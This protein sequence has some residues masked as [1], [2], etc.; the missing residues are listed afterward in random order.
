M[1]MFENDEEAYLNWVFS[2][3]NGFV[4][5]TPK[6]GRGY[7]N[8]LHRATCIHITTAHKNYTTTIYKKACS[9]NR[10][11]LVNSYKDA[12]NGF[13]GCRHCKP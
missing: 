3:P 8:M 10:Q 1:D 4:I 5:N 7:P 12:A 11:E 9:M 2:H 6:S 13:A